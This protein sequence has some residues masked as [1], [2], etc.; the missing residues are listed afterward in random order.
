VRT[1][2]VVGLVLAAGVLTL[3]PSAGAQSPLQ[4]RL[5][6]E[7]RVS[8]HAQT[9]HVRFVGTA[10][11]APIA[12]PVGV[13]A[14]ASAATVARAFLASYGDAFGIAD[15]AR[16]L[17][18][19]ASDD[20]SVRFQQ[21]QRGVP[22]LG[23]EL[24]VNLDSAGN[25]RS[26]SGETLPA[27][28]L[29]TTPRI[30]DAAARSTAL[31]AIA[32]YRSIAASALE[33]AP[34]QLWIYDSR[35]LGG[36]GLDRPELVW[37]TEVTARGERPVREL[38]LVDAV[39][40]GVSLHFDQIADAKNRR[41]CD[42]G[43]SARQV[44]CT[45]PVRTET[46]GSSSVADVNNAFDLSG[47]TY[48]F[49]LA[50]GRDSLDGA[51]LPLVSTVRY[52]IDN[53]FWDG[54]QMVF[55]PGY[56]AADDVVAHELTHGVTDFTSHLFYYSQSGAINE[57]LS[58]VMGE[59][60]DLTDGVG[61]DAAGVRWLVGEDI[62]GGAIRSMSNPP[63]FENP[64][65]T[66]SPLY[67]ADPGELDDGGVHT[68]SGVNNKA[69]F[70]ITDGGAFN[71]HAVSG[72]GPDK[73]AR[74]YYEVN[75]HLL[76]SASDYADLF[77]ALQQACANLVGSAGISADDCVQVR[78]AA[79]ATE[80]N[81]TPANAPATEAPMC[82]AGLV[83]VD[84]FVDDLENTGSG[85]WAPTVTDPPSA[86]SYPPPS[87]MVYATSGTNNI[88]GADVEAP[89]DSSFAMTSSVPLPAGAFMHFRHAYGFEDNSDGR[90]FDGGLLELSTD[91]G[92][93]WQD[94]GPLI[95]DNG[96]TGTLAAGSQNP[97]A[98]R[99]AFTAES[100]GYVSSRLDLASLAGQSVRFRFRIAT[101]VNTGDVGWFIDDVRI[102]TCTVPPTLTAGAARDTTRPR[103][104]LSGRRRQKARRTISIG[105]TAN[106]AV[107]ATITGTVSVRRS[108]RGKAK[109][110]RIRPIK[111]RALPAGRKVTLKLKVSSKTLAA[112]R[113]ALRRRGGRATARITI[114]ARDG[115]GNL[116]IARRAVTLRR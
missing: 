90:R 96:Y 24:V 64:D 36:P 97:L 11:G 92:A 83:P 18:V 78:E 69:A 3:A 43:N 48:D 35:L 5:G 109:R 99:T 34:P 89:S 25:V 72:L 77:D 95:T 46:G 51:G 14:G 108:A 54:R 29:S 112:I 30:E 76:T 2:V 19:T 86:W 38:V 88:W 40:G 110:Y 111:N 9:G 70:L 12:R 63:A 87:D 57:S 61:N 98:G 4:R 107:T 21:L 65:R 53:A 94:A 104:R 91:G 62:P 103:L 45:S 49:Y 33:A 39:R 114:R 44:P 7:V 32:K 93:T 105:L 56:A 80:M 1:P 75:T 22:V 41:V 100:N 26:A 73:A 101:D 20:V 79:L 71:G 50:L 116:T 115:A 47:R 66:G 74:I 10:A 102:Y 6:P 81:L 37:R 16:E 23:G 82:P 55:G 28:K 8:A 31:S 68:N 106:E 84:R 13:P 85:N 52:P 42:A 59:L 67:T 58:D 113:S 15:Q 27:T 17:R 60:M